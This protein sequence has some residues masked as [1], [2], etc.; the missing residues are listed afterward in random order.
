MTNME[1]NQEEMARV[2]GGELSAAV[3]EQIRA[4]MAEKCG[5]A[6]GMMIM[7]RAFAHR[8]KETLY[9]REDLWYNTEKGTDE[10]KEERA[11]RPKN[12]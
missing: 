7:R 9:S 10:E 12:S 11:W 8:R 6:S 2:S 3:M 5:I 1:L 4:A